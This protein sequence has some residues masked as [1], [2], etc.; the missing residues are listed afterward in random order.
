MLRARRRILNFHWI[1]RGIDSRGKTRAV[2]V[3]YEKT[4][5]QECC[6]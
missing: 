6:W 5:T 2:M 4:I 3:I 1:V